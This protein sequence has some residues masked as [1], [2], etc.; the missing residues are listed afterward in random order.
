MARAAV[1]NAWPLIVAVGGDGTVNEVINGLIDKPGDPVSTV[2]TIMT[3]RGRDVCRALAVPSVPEQAADRLAHGKDVLVDVG[4]AEWGVTRRRLFLVAA[5]AGFDA[6]VAKRAQSLGGS[7]TVPY[8]RALL[9]ALGTHRA[10][11]AEVRVDGRQ[12]WAGM[13]TAAVAAN[14]AY[15]G[16]GMMIAPDADVT[17]G[18]LDL[19]VIGGLGRGELLRWL[20]RVY[21]GTHLANPKV[22]VYRG[23]TFEILT[24]PAVPT[25]V[26]GEAAPPTPVRITIRERALRVRR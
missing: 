8:L 15:F 3:G 7:G 11:S 4:M 22:T 17:D 18:I 25:H 2:G 16:G 13:L 26:D 9:G 21:R 23:T 10:V 12:A 1:R 20:P 19:V 14:G 5:G 24:T 6:I